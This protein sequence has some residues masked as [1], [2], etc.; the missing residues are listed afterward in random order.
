VLYADPATTT[1]AI[2]LIGNEFDN[3][4]VGNDGINVLVGGLGRRYV[5]R[6]RRRPTGSCGRPS[7]R[8]ACPARTSSR[9]TAAR[10]ATCS[11]SPTSMRTRRADDQNFTFISTEAFTAA[12]QI[13]WFTNGTDTFIQFNTT[14]I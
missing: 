13:N 1:A 9:T 5:A 6:Q 14:P 8:S 7:T 3:F 11:T 4:V 2:N 10:R 12:G